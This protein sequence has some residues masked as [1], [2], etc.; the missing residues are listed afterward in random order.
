MPIPKTNRCASGF[1][2]TYARASINAARIN[3]CGAVSASWKWKSFRAY[4]GCV[5]FVDT[6]IDNIDLII[7]AAMEIVIALATGAG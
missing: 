4:P 1:R 5:C 2:G 7:D 6:L 3:G